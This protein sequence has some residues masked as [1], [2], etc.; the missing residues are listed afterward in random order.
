MQDELF[1]LPSEEEMK[2]IVKN[3]ERYESLKNLINSPPANLNLQETMERMLAQKSLW[4]EQIS[5]IMERVK[6]N[7][8][9]LQKYWSKEPEGC[10]SRLLSSIQ[11]AVRL[12][13]RAYLQ[14]N[15][16]SSISLDLF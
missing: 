10:G 16:P 14:E 4:P 12:E 9:E 7:S 6:A 5:A 15:C 13:A 1:S 11:F 2:E 8:P 3:L